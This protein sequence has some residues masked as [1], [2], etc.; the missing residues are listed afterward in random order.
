MA[1]VHNFRLAVPGGSEFVRSCRMGTVEA[2]S[3][4]GDARLIPHTSV[5]VPDADVGREASGLT[6][7]DYM[8][9]RGLV[10]AGLNHEPAREVGPVPSSSKP[11]RSDPQP[12]PER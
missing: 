3:Q 5:E 7:R 4:L 8:P 6:M 11:D 1:T 2:I 10:G 9:R 12:S